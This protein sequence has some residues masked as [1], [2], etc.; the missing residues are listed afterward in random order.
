[1]L[2]GCGMSNEEKKAYADQIK[3]HQ[4]LIKA[5]DRDR[6]AAEA[7]GNIGLAF[8]YTESNLDAIKY[9]DCMQGYEKIG[10]KFAKAKTACT[11]ESGARK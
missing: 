4:E 1:M 11:L 7:A 9:I 10:E 8:S 3:A 5:F 6:A 2:V